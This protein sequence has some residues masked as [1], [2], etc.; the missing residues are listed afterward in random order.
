MR[1]ACALLIAFGWAGFAHALA[2][3]SGT[4]DPYELA[5]LKQHGVKGER[6]DLLTYLKDR[7]LDDAKIKRIRELIVETGHARFAVR[8]RAAR[9][10]LKFGVSAI[11]FLEEA[12]KNKDPEV[13]DRAG[14]LLDQIQSGPGAS[15]PIA[16]LRQLR[17]SLAHDITIAATIDVDL[18]M[19]SALSFEWNF[20]VRL[21]P[22]RVFADVVGV[23][24]EF[25]P[26]ADDSSVE[27]EVLQT[28]V[29][30]ALRNGNP[31]PGVGAFLKNKFA[32][33]R[34]AAGY[35][36][37]RSRDAANVASAQMLLADADPW[38]R[39]RT[40]QGLIAG[41]QRDAIPALIK[42]VDPEIPEI[43]WR[44]EDLL[45]R[46]AAGGSPQA[47]PDAKAESRKAYVDA[48]QA[49]W[50]TNGKSVDLAK[51]TSD[52]PLLNLWV[53]IEF[54]TNSVWECTRDGK[55][56]W[57]ISAE[58]PMD[59]Q[60]LRGN[61]VLIAEQSAQRVTER[62]MKGKILWQY[63]AKEETLNCKRLPNG[64]T[65]IGTRHNVMEIRPDKSVAFTYKMSDQY[66]HAV[67]RLPSG[68]FVGITSRG[69]IHEMNAAG[70]MVRTVNVP[71]E[72]TWGD[73]DA[74]PN[75]NY[76]VSN[77]GAGFVRE[78]DRTGKTIR[79]VKSPA[80]TGVE[81]L[82]NGQLLVGGGESARIID[83]NGRETW[84]TKSNGSIRRIHSR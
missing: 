82:P 9:E 7:T 61:R 30:L 8:D 39:L 16:V 33:R 60:V 44:A 64:N 23:L 14:R 49:W 59:A 42:L 1:A 57:T 40:A 4:D 75:G 72:G 31:E 55:R 35:I 13:V 63:D 62:D 53:G 79:E 27:D 5:F 3:A 51:L 15:L 52:S 41:E 19:P 29:K 26:F 25:I 71:H 83:W 21:Q 32:S 45:R 48:W 37:G 43:T 76:L 70:N 6:T 34:A 58:G 47:P 73:V 74:L 69:A 12:R 66:M 65:W 84:S 11:R 24:L 78:V 20:T 2:D 81:R 77:Y 46:I 50:Q 10:L 67:R 36:L 18:R 56:L 80:S 17:K 38:V 28:L 22:D 68:N 54:N